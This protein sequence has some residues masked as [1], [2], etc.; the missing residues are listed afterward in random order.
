MMVSQNVSQ[1]AA[2]RLGSEMMLRLRLDCKTQ[3]RILV[4]CAILE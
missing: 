2:E 3:N 1:V 4:S